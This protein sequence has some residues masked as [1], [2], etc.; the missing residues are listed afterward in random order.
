MYIKNLKIFK[1]ILK[2]GILNKLLLFNSKSKKSSIFY[3]IENS[4]KIS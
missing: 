4:N 1:S 3:N 2:K